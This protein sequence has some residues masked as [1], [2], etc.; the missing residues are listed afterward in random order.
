MGEV[1]NSRRLGDL[2]GFCAMTTLWFR[3]RLPEDEEAQPE[4][5]EPLRQRTTTAG[6]LSLRQWLVILCVA[7]MLSVALG[8]P[9]SRLL[10][11]RERIIVVGAGLAG[12]AAARALQDCCDVVVLEARDRLGGRVWTDHSLGVPVEFG[13]VWIHRATHNVLTELADAH[14]CRHIASENKRLALYG[15]G[16]ER[17]P[18]QL[19][20][21]TYTAL[22][23]HIMPVFLRRRDALRQACREQSRGTPRPC[24][25]LTMA[26]RSTAAQH[27]HVCMAGGAGYRHG[28]PD[29]GHRGGAGG[30]G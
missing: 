20:A 1:K 26:L 28:Q 30:A 15:V 21:R 14:G 5:D 8:I 4:D 25:I 29:G 22:T 7:L 18:E 23:R 24:P 11:R 9:L 19:V 16:G 6:R 12:L 13:A 2:C 3:R 17:L 27:G 10:R